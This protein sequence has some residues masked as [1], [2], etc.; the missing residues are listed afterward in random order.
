MHARCK[1]WI[2]YEEK[3]MG[4]DLIM[5]LGFGMRFLLLVVEVHLWRFVDAL[6]AMI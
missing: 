2:R 6:M 5:R 4:Q 1:V 3:I